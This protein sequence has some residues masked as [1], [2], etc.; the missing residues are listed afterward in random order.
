MTTVAPEVNPIGSVQQLDAV[1][2]RVNM[3]AEKWREDNPK[4]KWW[5]FWKKGTTLYR[6]VKF[7]INALDELILM[8]DDM[9][10]NGADKKAT[11]VAA[12]GLLYDYIIREAMPIWL[13]PFAGKIRKLI[14]DVL[15][16]TAIDWIVAK[17]RTGTWRKSEEETNG[18]ES[19][20]TG[21][22]AEAQPE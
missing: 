16:V 1:E 11:V 18:G 15:V 5:Q 4:P 2:Q 9:I 14:I 21:A 13:R 7:I 19:T 22:Q 17:Y 20:H 10:D 12:V 6:V 3:L 8:V